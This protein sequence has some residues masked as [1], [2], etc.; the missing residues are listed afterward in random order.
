MRGLST[1]YPLKI[2]KITEISM[3]LNNGSITNYVI[4]EQNFTNPT[5]SLK[6]SKDK[7]R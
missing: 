5:I 6:N 3:Q 4:I 2:T 7:K 1:I